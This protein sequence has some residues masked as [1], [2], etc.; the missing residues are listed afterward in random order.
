MLE[1]ELPEGQLLNVKVRVRGEAGRITEEGDAWGGRA[2]AHR[3]AVQGDSEIVLPLTGW[4]D[5]R[6]GK[7]RPGHAHPAREEWILSAP[8]G[9]QAVR[10]WW[11][12]ETGSSPLPLLIMHDGQNV[13]DEASTFAG[14]SWDVGA[15]A[16]QLADE[17]YPC[18]IAALPVG[19]D[20]NHRYV[21]FGF[22]LNDFA[23]TTEPYLDW[24]AQTLLP[25]LA[26]RF[27][28]TAPKDRA[29][30]GSSFGGLVTL[31]GGLRAPELFGTLGVFSPAIWPADFALLRWLQGRS[32][33]QTRVWLDMG[34]HEATSLS[35]AAEVVALTYRLA[36]EHL[37]KKVAEIKL[38]IGEGHWHDEAA[39]AIRFPAFLRWWLLGQAQDQDS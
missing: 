5:E 30:A 22:E 35:G 23:P 34:D 14:Q 9:M 12:T 37:N 21:P 11:P 3:A 8:W 15:A 1:A 25:G 33:P 18:L 7:D 24:I 19:K 2:P 32:A 36:E 10:L 16:Q 6:A 28:E 38:T 26:K 29:L 20:R 17:G 27:G 31:Y 13:F 4:Q 39:W